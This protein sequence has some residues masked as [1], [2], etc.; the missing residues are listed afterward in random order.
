MAIPVASTMTTVDNLPGEEIEFT[1][2]DARWVMRSMADLYSNRELAVAR[3]YSTNAY[4]EHV[5][6]NVE[7]PIEVTLPTV[8]DPYFR[9][10]DFA[11]GMSRVVLT[12][13]YTKFGESTK[14][15][16]DDFNGML[17]FGS[18]SAIAYTTSFKVT[19]IYDGLKTIAVVSRKPDYSI[20]LK[21][22]AEVKT[23][24]PSGVEIEV[25]VHNAAEFSQKANDFY[26]FWLP[27]RVLVD[28]AEPASAVGEALADNLYYNEASG[29]SYVVMGNVPYR[30]INPQAL[31]YDKSMNAINFVAYVEN[32]AVE[33]T[34]SRE[35]LKYTDA[36]K[37]RLHKIIADFQKEIKTKAQT[38]INTAT[39]HAEAYNAWVK[40]CN[41]LGSSV[42]TDLSFHG[43]KL[44]NTFAIDAMRYAVTSYRTRNN[45]HRVNTWQVGWAS[46]TLFV[47]G[48][49][50]EVTSNHKRKAKD[51]CEFKGMTFLN[52]NHLPGYVLFT[53]DTTVNSKWVNAGS[54]VSW[55]TIKKELPRNYKTTTSNNP[56]RIPGSFDIITSSGREYEKSIPDDGDVFWVTA[57]TARERKSTIVNALTTLKNDGTVIILGLNRLAKFQRENPDVEE[58][59]KWA[60]VHVDTDPTRH[61]SDDAKELL[62]LGDETERWVQRL[63]LSKVDDPAFKRAKDLLGNKT[64]LL[65]DYLA[66]LK[67][68]E[69]LGVYYNIKK[70]TPKVS[71]N[72]LKKYPLL[73]EFRYYYSQTAHPDI[74]LY[75]N[76]AYAARKEN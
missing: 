58:F 31:F 64:A 23:D 73:K 76:A 35:D 17:G 2:G 29:E 68:A 48:V 1:I 32:G 55:D 18:K 20:V 46:N 51:F 40:W 22:V 74:Y 53:K 39:D 67:V 72:L 26:K 3:E 52:G 14:R 27:G 70:Y 34:P 47:T 59:F 44:E 63:N 57:A 56:S 12:E 62:S 42:F 69:T 61:L 33:F 11:A 75:M 65:K 71:D 8:M 60:A 7:R 66:A 5:K 54:I 4:D 21:V 38:E 36:T 28:G 19:S 10:R 24:E 30:I 41:L 37:N 25:P 9:V 16:S 49:T 6:F 13:V 50:G 45:M 15:H 43:D